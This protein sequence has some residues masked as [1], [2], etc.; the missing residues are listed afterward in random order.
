MRL[1]GR[2]MRFGIRRAEIRDADDNSAI[3]IRAGRRRGQDIDRA[4][5][6]DALRARGAC[7]R[8]DG[9]LRAQGIQ[10]A[11]GAREARAADGYAPRSGR[12]LDTRASDIPAE[13]GLRRAGKSRTRAQTCAAPAEAACG[14]KQRACVG[15]ARSCPGR[16]IRARN[17]TRGACA[18]RRVALA[19]GPERA[20][21]GPLT[22]LRIVAGHNPAP[23]ASLD[24]LPAGP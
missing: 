22:S 21:A 18:L 7:S 20:D 11:N 13:P 3:R 12:R 24:P 1:H 15:C 17:A 10:A 14:C 9:E 8:L 2:W 6:Q 19:A 23:K 4:N 5:L 16:A